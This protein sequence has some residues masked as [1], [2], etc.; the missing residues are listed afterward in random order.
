MAFLGKR[1]ALEHGFYGL[2]WEMK[3]LLWISHGDGCGRSIRCL[4]YVSTPSFVSRV[5][6]SHKY[7]GQPVVGQHSNR[8]P[9]DTS[10]EC[11]QHNSGNIQRN[12]RN[13]FQSVGWTTGILGFDSRGVGNFYLHH[14]VQ[15]G[16]GA[17]PASSIMGT[18]AISL[19]V[20]PAREADHSPPSS[21]EV[22]E[23]VELYIHSPSTPSW[24]GA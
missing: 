9:S 18:R 22:K 15:N 3:I 24:R 17:H 19:G 14:R 23:W 2:E 4:F 5:E 12:S 21:A 6:K 16:S 20:K 7:P 10:V 13:F 8:M 11:N 1:S